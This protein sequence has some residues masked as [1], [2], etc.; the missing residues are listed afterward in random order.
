MRR[1]W[2]LKINEKF[3]R[4]HLIFKIIEEQNVRRALLALVAKVKPV[5]QIA[6]HY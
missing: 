1:D 3:L 4:T 2:H 6:Q 5:V